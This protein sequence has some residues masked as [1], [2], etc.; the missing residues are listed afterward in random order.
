LGLTSSKVIDSDLLPANQLEVKKTSLEAAA[1]AA[2]AAL[3]DH[4][5]REKLEVLL[6]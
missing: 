3:N 2:R 4:V 6:D 5:Q 1:A